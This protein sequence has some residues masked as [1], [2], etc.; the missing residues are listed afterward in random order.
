MRVYRNFINFYRTL[1][2][3]GD[4]LAI[5]KLLPSEAFYFFASI[6]NFIGRIA[7]SHEDFLREIRDVDVKSLEFHM[8]REDF[9]KWATDVLRD[10]KLAREIRDLRNECARDRPL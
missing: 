5:R 2:W 10:T 9:E 8:E 3:L 4:M 7:A 1:F 6:G